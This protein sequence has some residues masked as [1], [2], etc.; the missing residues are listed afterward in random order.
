MGSVTGHTTVAIR[1][2]ED[3]KLYIA[4]S[5]VNSSYWDTNGIQR[6]EYGEWMKAAKKAGFNVVWEP[7]SA[8]M[9]RKFDAS[10]AMDFFKKNEGRKCIE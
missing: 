1:D 10:A 8:E 7:L 4:E 6:T 5:T 3:G 9:R 2:P